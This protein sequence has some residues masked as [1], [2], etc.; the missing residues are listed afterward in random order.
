MWLKHT[1]IHS[2][3]SSLLKLPH[4]MCTPAICKWLATSPACQGAY[5]G[6]TILVLLLT[7][8]IVALATA[9]ESS[10]DPEE[11]EVSF[12]VIE[13]MIGLLIYIAGGFMMGSRV[14]APACCAGL[15]DVP[16]C[17][18][19]SCFAQLD[20]P[21]YIWFG[22]TIAMSLLGMM[23]S[24]VMAA[25]VG[26]LRLVRIIGPVLLI[27]SLVCA[28]IKLCI[29]YGICCQDLSPKAGAQQTPQP[30]NQPVIVGQLY[31]TH[32]SWNYPEFETLGLNMSRI[33]KYKP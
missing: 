11:Q 10:D 7:G 9:N 22:F 20:L 23:L 32:G 31:V 4:V 17:C 30:V 19:C 16:P 1:R 27:A 5:V 6:I 25:D 14:C 3:V 15:E 21:F 29:M 12:L 33:P 2:V 8:A 18:P 26:S 28:I 13:G 24:F